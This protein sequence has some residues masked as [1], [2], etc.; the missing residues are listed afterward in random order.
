MIKD[1]KA[2]VGLNPYNF[3]LIGA[4][5]LLLALETYQVFKGEQIED[6][7]WS[8]LFYSGVLSITSYFTFKNA[9]EYKKVSK[10]I[11]DNGFST[12]LLLNRENIRFVNAYANANDKEFEL[13]EALTETS[14]LVEYLYE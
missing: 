2:I 14:E 10:Q 12:E 9:L 11:E 1:L 13:N 3:G 4:S 7:A 8:C 6:C 5:A